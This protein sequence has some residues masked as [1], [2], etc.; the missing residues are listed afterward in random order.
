MSPAGSGS[1]HFGGG[2][3]PRVTPGAVCTWILP[4]LLP[5]GLFGTVAVISLPSPFGL[6]L[7]GVWGW[8]AF[9][10]VV[11]YIRSH[12]RADGGRNNGDGFRED[13]ADY[14]RTKLM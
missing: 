1:G 8:V 10:C 5:V 12:S 3:S 9:P 2:L 7:A 13:E 14:W 6:L 4:W 11:V